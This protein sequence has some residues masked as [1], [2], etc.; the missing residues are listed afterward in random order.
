MYVYVGPRLLVYVL[1][2]CNQL[3]SAV[4]YLAIP[5]TTA[6]NP[7]QPYNTYTCIKPMKVAAGNT[8]EIVRASLSSFVVMLY[9]VC[10]LML[11][12][13]W[14]LS[15]GCQQLLWLLSMN[16]WIQYVL[17][18]FQPFLFIFLSPKTINTSSLIV[19]FFKNFY[20]NLLWIHLLMKKPEKTT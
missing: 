8:F 7:I 16:S 5:H 11:S 3:R 15:A 12:F 13:H 18:S 9:G 2:C 20:L 10:F 4:Q 1:M 17:F 6:Y 19:C 14:L